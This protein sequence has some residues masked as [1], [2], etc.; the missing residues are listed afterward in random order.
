[1]KKI[2]VIPLL[3][4][5]LTGCS[6]GD[7]FT[8]PDGV[9]I[10]FDKTGD[11]DITLVL[12]HGWSCDR[13]YWQQQVEG[14]SDEFTI[15]T[16]D[17]AGHGDS[18]LQ[19]EDYTMQAFG[20]DVAAV[21]NGLNLQNVY[22]VGH[23][24]GGSVIVEAAPFLEGRLKG[25]IGIDTLQEPRFAFEETQ[26]DAFLHPMRE[27]FPE[28]V[29]GF[30]RGMFPA[31]A[32]SAIVNRVAGDMASAP[33]EV[34]LSAMRN[35]LLNDLAVTLRQLDLPIFC[36]NANMHPIDFEAWQFYRSGYTAVVM[37]GLGHFLF[38]EDPE[39]FNA[40]LKD[41]VARMQD[42]SARKAG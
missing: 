20:R 34:A 25:L 38:L 39:G 42:F 19:R 4:L 26:V 37:E 27:N 16:L 29:D 22:L 31:D 14:L 18:G 13:S 15:V 30:V 6:G 11:G 32:D 35:M 33:P 7:T 21:V 41:L 1:M 10:A 12:V 2:L 8:S 17:L 24:M 36:L 23:S 3:L 5:L 28:A 40:Q 9:P